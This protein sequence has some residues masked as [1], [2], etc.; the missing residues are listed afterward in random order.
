MIPWKVLPCPFAAEI[1]AGHDGRLGA[2]D[3]AR[4]DRH[5]ATCA[6]CRSLRAGLDALRAEARRAAVGV[7]DLDRHRARVSLLHRAAQP[8]PSGGRARFFAGA[9][10]MASLALLLLGGV[11]RRRSASPHA[12]ARVEAEAGAA[13]SRGAAAQAEF[14]TLTDGVIRVMVPHQHAGHRFV[15][16]LPDGQIEVRGTRFEVEVR[17][18]RTRRVD[19]AEGLVALRLAGRPER[20]LAAGSRWESAD[21]PS[22]VAAAPIAPTSLLP[23]PSPTSRA[24]PPVHP[25]LGAAL[26]T[27]ASGLAAF[28]RGDLATAAARFAAFEAAHP[29]DDRAEDAG[30]LRLLSLRRA[31]SSAAAGAAESYLRRYPRGARRWDALAQLAAA[32]RTKLTCTEVAALD[33]EFGAD[34]T[35]HATL[36][37]LLARCR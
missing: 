2:V 4:I 8:G 21:L 36:G 20:L 13:W 11:Q 19:V 23:A 18:R 24:D 3:L 1:E 5:L 6:P 7:P 25:T 26:P 32:G 37:P 33:A 9:L 14:I 30:Y 34:P 10:V 17:D 12:L 15:V 31:G 28:G 35:G 29:A 27:Y 16:T 22:R